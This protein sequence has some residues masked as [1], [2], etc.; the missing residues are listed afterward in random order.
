M[1]D[2]G[3]AHGELSWTADDDHHVIAAVTG[4]SISLGRLLNNAESVEG[5]C[6]AALH[7]AMLNTCV[8]RFRAAR[9]YPAC[10]VYPSASTTPN[11]SASL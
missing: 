2:S 9:Y 11:H 7:S 8:A 3:K 4:R 10:S 5:T 1:D 6:R